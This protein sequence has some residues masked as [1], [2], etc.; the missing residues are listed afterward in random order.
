[1]ANEKPTD[2]T[3]VDQGV[4]V[5]TENYENQ[6]DEFPDKG[7]IYLSPVTDPQKKTDTLVFF[8]HFFQGHKKAL[9]RHY[10][11]VN[12][13]GFDA[14]GFNLND[15]AK[16]H[17]YLPY[18]E[19][20]HK[21]G[22][23]HALA[24]QIQ[25]HLDLV[26]DRFPQRK[27]VVFAFSNV[28]GCAIEAMARK[29]NSNEGTQFSALVCDSGPGAQFFF[30]SFKLIEQQLKVTSLPLKIIG[31]PLVAYGWSPSLNKDIAADLN[32]FP[33]HFPVLSIRGWKDKLIAPKHI[34]QIFEGAKSIQWKKLSLPLAEH[35]T[36]LRDYPDEYKP[37]V[38]NFLN[39]FKST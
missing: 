7:E 4:D 9:K 32:E 13:L 12:E 36:G 24:D 10:D 35:L 14:Y 6:H 26:M 25:D 17:Y 5:T 8:C 30:S 20:S 3:L 33:K 27:I 28:A 21:F 1:M 16:N 39:D 22:M 38:Q 23:K 19:R 29:F 15:S 11:F 2:K 34:D 31:T 37:Q 18:S